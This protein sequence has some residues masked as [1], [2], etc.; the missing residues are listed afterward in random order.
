[1]TP[2]TSV[3]RRCRKVTAVSALLVPLGACF[4][5]SPVPLESV[6]PDQQARVTLD[7]DGFGRVMNHAAVEGFPVQMMNLSDNRISGRVATVSADNLT[8]QLRGGGASLLTTQVATGSIQEIAIRQFDRSNTI[9]AIGG[10]VGAA[11]AMIWGG[12]V[13]GTTSPGPPVDPEN[14]IGLRLF[15]ISVP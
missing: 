13:G 10:V 11:T 3:L 15:S 2:A 6:S 4:T 14:M 5:Y 8:I 7:Q 9:L 12:T 1:M